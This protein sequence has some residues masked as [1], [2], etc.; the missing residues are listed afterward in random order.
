M[1]DAKTVQKPPAKIMTDLNTDLEKWKRN[2]APPAD[3]KRR[4]YL[5][6]KPCHWLIS[7]LFIAGFAVL[8][9]YLTNKKTNRQTKPVSAPVIPTAPITLEPMTLKKIT[10]LQEKPFDYQVSDY[11]TQFIYLLPDDFIKIGDPL[12]KEMTAWYDDK[13]LEGI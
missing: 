13:N 5:R 9:F 8:C 12:I 2:S 10:L 4:I 6:R 3:K 11:Y 1:I 7:L